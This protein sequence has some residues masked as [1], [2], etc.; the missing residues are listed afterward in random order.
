[1]SDIR[2]TELHIAGLKKYHVPVLDPLTITEVRAKD[3]D[4]DMVGRDIK[5][6]GIRNILLKNVR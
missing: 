6:E 3:G 2:L 5:V 4:L 1:M